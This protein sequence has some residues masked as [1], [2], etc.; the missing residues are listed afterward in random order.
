MAFQQPQRPQQRPSSFSAAPPPIQTTPQQRQQS[1]PPERQEWVLFSPHVASDSYDQTDSTIQTDRITGRLS[2]FGSLETAAASE[3]GNAR[4]GENAETEDLDSLDDGLHAFNEPVPSGH[5][6]FLEQSGD[7]IMPSH[8]G[9]GLFPGN[10]SPLQ[11]QFWQH[12]KYN[13]RRRRSLRRSSLQVKAEAIDEQSPTTS[14]E[15]EKTQRIEQWRDEQSKA[16]LEEIEKETRRRRRRSRMSINKSQSS[17]PISQ[18]A[19]EAREPPPPPPS[20]TQRL[21][22]WE[23]LTRRVIRDLIGIDDATLEYIFGESLPEES[24]KPQPSAASAI[25]DFAEKTIADDELPTS[26]SGWEDKLLGRIAKELGILFNHISDHPGAFS[27]YLRTQEVPTYAGLPNP[28]GDS[29]TQAKP[30]PSRKAPSNSDTTATG[31]DPQ[32][33]PTLGHHHHRRHSTLTMDPSLW[34][35]EEEEE[36]ARAPSASAEAARLKRVKEYWEQDLDIKMVFGFLR[37]RLTSSPTSPAQGPP[38]PMSAQAASTAPPNQTDSLRR[39][40]L[41]RHHHPLVS[42]SSATTSQQQQRL[43]RVPSGTSNIIT[44]S[45]VPL[46]PI[47]GRRS[48][49]V[50]DTESCASQSTKRSRTNRSGSSRNYWDLGGRSD[51]A[52]ETFNTGWGQ[53]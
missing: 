37:N 34:G 11:E 20:R 39:A 24:P 18:S 16:I 40:A 3:G 46:S 49:R 22:F 26:T 27:T 53:V 50:A 8:D 38:S 29:R 42:R 30:I 47:L 32:F 35:I 2:D 41:I 1:P 33:A 13:P 4:E 7:S 15:D 31:S 12:E 48:S 52:S 43:C 23:R 17:T 19:P 51:I 44:S 6:G 36:E 25:V 21:S 10:S 45:G 28:E 14:K 5:R 9:L